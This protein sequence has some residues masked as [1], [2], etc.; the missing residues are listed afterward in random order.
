LRIKSWT[1]QKH[2]PA[3]TA[4]S[5]T[6]LIGQK[7]YPRQPFP[8]P[9]VAALSLEGSDPKLELLPKRS[10][11]DRK[12]LDAYLETLE[13]CLETLYRV[14]ETLYPRLNVPQASLQ[15]VEALA[16]FRLE[17]V[18]PLVDILSALDDLDGEHVEEV[19]N[20]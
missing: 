18:Y 11:L 14:L 1:P 4:R 15:A 7:F 9:G 6:V 2:P 17:G 12:T 10:L 19:E 8:F 3:R 13:P 20:P 16:H 5:V